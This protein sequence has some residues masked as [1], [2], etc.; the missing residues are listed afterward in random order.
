M[1]HDSALLPPDEML[2]RYQWDLSEK[3]LDNRSAMYESLKSHDDIKNF[4]DNIERL[5][6]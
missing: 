4:Q 1:N 6:I 5:R 2:L 3:T